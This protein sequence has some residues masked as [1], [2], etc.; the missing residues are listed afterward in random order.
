[1]LRQS[2]SLVA[3]A[4]FLWHSSLRTNLDPEELYD[5]QDLWAALDRVEMSA[6]VSALPEKLDTVLEDSGSFSKG[7]RQ[8]LCLARVLLRKRNIVILDEASGSLD[9][10]ADARM[11]EV[12]RSDLAECTVIAVAHRIA[13]IIDFDLI[14][15]MENGSIVERGSPKDLLAVSNSRFARLAA[16][17]GL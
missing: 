9:L 6:A 10:K 5:E 2:L 16:A 11:R 12:I 14:L 15:V 13:T 7:Q 17:Q 1:L 4:P 3:Q 8:L